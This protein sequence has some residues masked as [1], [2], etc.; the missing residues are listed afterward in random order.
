[1]KPLAKLIGQPLAVELL[2]R[3]IAINRI[4]PA[5][6][7]VGAKGVGKGYG[8]RC[9]AEMLMIRPEDDYAAMVQKNTGRKPP[10]FPLGRAYIHR[11]R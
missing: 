5:Y 3:A 9:F 11:K 4:A 7:F 8:A 2:E 6:L 10:R 1:M